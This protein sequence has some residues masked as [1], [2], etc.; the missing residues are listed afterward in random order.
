MQIHTLF[1]FRF[2]LKWQ[3]PF[4]YRARLAVE[5]QFE[6][7]FKNIITQKPDSQ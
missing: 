5:T 6:T 7:F 1:I 2:F 4:L 3:L